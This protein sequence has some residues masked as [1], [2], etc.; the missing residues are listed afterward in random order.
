[1]DRSLFPTPLRAWFVFDFPPQGS[2]KTGSTLATIPHA[3]RGLTCRYVLAVS[4]LKD[5][6]RVKC[7]CRGG[8]LT[9]V[10]DRGCR[11]WGARRGYG[12]LKLSS[13]FKLRDDDSTRHKTIVS[14]KNL[15]LK[16]RPTLFKSLFMSSTI[17]QDGGCDELG[18]GDANQ[19]CRTLKRLDGGCRLK[20]REVNSCV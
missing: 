4:P 13:T 9:V 8:R 17:S 1:M 12:K 14:I 10:L 20:N 15:L 11:L 19:E 5:S 16:G 18:R 7:L 6:E 2:A 3:L